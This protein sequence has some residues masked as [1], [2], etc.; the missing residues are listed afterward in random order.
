MNQSQQMKQHLS[1]APALQKSLQLLQ[2]NALEFAQEINESLDRNPLLERE[3][4]G[5]DPL[6][7]ATGA[8][9][10]DNVQTETMAM[11]S[12]SEGSLGMPQDDAGSGSEETSNN[13]QG[14]LD[15]V[16]SATESGVQ[17]SFEAS[18]DASMVSDFANFESNANRRQASDDGFSALDLVASE[19]SL[20]SHL[21]EQLGAMPLPDRDHAFAAL[22]VDSL[23]S[24][25]YL[26]ESSEELLALA[27]GA[28]A[29]AGAP[30]GDDAPGFTIETIE[31]A[32]IEIAIQRVRS[33][34]PI[35]IAAGNV[36][37]CLALQLRA[38]AADTEGLG[39]ATT[40]VARH[41]DLLGAGDFRALA[42]ATDANQ[43]ELAAAV[44]L[45]RTLNPKPGAAFATDRIDYAVPEVIVRKVGRHWQARLH[46]SATPRVR[47]NAAYA[48]IVSRHN[49]SC[50]G[51]S[52]QL[53]Q[54]RWLLRSIDQRAS[55]IEKTAQ[56]I[57]ARQQGWFEHGDIGL[58]PMRLS[59]IAADIGIHESTVSRVVNSKYLQCP[60]GLI[61]LKRF[62]TSH[63]E[64]SGGDACSAAAVKAMIKQLIDQESGNDPLSD[65][66]LAK[67][68]ERRGIRIA[69]RTVTKYRDALG[70]EALEMRRH[71]L[72]TL[73][74]GT[75]G[76][77]AAREDSGRSRARI[78]H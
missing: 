23:D 8:G 72:R 73:D 42:A 76:L 68:L 19:K 6:A 41:L 18:D 26:R 25:G 70:I 7:A 77:V 51:M 4:D 47:I 29:D 20:R 1:I 62:F 75:I 40:I 33:L 65:H 64:T 44:R 38:L 71:A 53:A 46:P 49:G 28:L 21:L 43:A 31:P 69:R 34:D 60:R 50:A 14:W 56:A 37:E 67:M 10:V 78:V 32:D 9:D 36:A 66:R 48:E 16:G 12:A 45:I 54:A 35:G 52:E 11:P 55:T 39:L 30:G 27:R 17:A 22:I 58:Q 2:M 61:S 5:I 74:A 57:V 15:G 59:D 3:E 24:A 13:E 63:V